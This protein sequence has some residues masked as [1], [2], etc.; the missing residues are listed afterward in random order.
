MISIH[1]SNGRALQGIVLAFGDRLMRVAVKGSD[2]TVE[3]RLVNQV[4]VSE[5]CEVVKVE[6][7]ESRDSRSGQSGRRTGIPGPFPVP[8]SFVA[9]GDVAA[10]AYRERTSRITEVRIGSNS[11]WPNSRRMPRPM[12]RVFSIDPPQLEP[13]MVTGMGCGQNTGWPEINAW[14]HPL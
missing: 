4:W 2:D 3:F 5:D 13:W 8:G 9:T 14:S 6:F 1:Y 7:A 12:N 10:A 11:G